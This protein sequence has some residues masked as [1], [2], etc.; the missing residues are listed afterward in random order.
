LSWGKKKAQPPAIAGSLAANLATLEPGIPCP[1][2][3]PPSE[4]GETRMKPGWGGGD[5]QAGAIANLR[6]AAVEV[7]RFT[8]SRVWSK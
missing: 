7:L 6:D 5:K 1:V 2:A 8:P 3:S 4:S